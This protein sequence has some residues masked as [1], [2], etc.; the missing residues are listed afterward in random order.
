[1][2]KKEAV[3]T[4]STSS[5]AFNGLPSAGCFLLMLLQITTHMKSHM[6]GEIYQCAYPDSQQH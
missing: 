1:M 6:Y 4:E 5:Q 2:H 3:F